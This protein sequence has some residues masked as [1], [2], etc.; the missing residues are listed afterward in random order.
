MWA[1]VVK[2]ST[3]RQSPI[4]FDADQPQRLQSQRAQL[5]TAQTLTQRE[6]AV[7]LRRRGAIGPSCDLP[8]V[9]RVAPT[10][11]AE[12]AQR[13]CQNLA[14][15]GPLCETVRC[16]TRFKFGPPAPARRDRRDRTD[17]DLCPLSISRRN[18]FQRRSFWDDSGIDVAPEGDEQFPRK[19]DNADASH[20]RTPVPKSLLIPARQ[21]TQRLKA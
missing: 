2:S 17:R 21:R 8:S 19:G 18:S 4:L 12:Y 3:S 5:P 11:Y 10:P 14:A 20:P 7:L 16:R 15:S 6:L 1:M 13:L 9:G